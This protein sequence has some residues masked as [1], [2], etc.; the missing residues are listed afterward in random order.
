MFG[1]NKCSFIGRFVLQTV[2]CREAKLPLS[3]KFSSKKRSYQVQAKPNKKRSNIN[4]QDK[5]N[6]HHLP[7]HTQDIPKTYPRHTQ[8]IP[9]QFHHPM[10]LFSK[11]A[12]CGFRLFGLLFLLLQPHVRLGFGPD[13]GKLFWAQEMVEEL[14]PR[15]WVSGT[16]C[17]ER[18]EKRT[19]TKRNAKKDAGLSDL[20]GTSGSKMINDPNKSQHRNVIRTNKSP[21]L[22]YA[23]SKS[24]QIHGLSTVHECGLFTPMFPIWLTESPQK[25][26]TFF[27][28]SA[29]VK[30]RP[31]TWQPSLATLE[32]SGVQSFL[33]R[34]GNC[35]I[36]IPKQYITKFQKWAHLHVRV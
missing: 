14:D 13:G 34:W 7:R 19:S 5:K 6:T 23:Y 4:K 11:R 26:S 9:R 21:G 32:T 16:V 10:A 2:Q 17:L 1:G 3:I 35:H 31:T 30:A 24:I 12:T 36:S 27:P 33:W 20:P 8:D 28:C 22:C 25:A 18:H 29:K 15:C